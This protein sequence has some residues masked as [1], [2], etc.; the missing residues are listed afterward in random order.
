MGMS[1][2]DGEALANGFLYATNSLW[3]AERD[4]ASLT[5]VQALHFMHVRYS[6]LLVFASLCFFPTNTRYIATG[7]MDKIGWPFS[8]LN[9]LLQCQT[10]LVLTGASPQTG[11]QC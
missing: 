4:R 11:I 1:S 10:I 6:F 3:E 5:N 9:R 8:F 7:A 2:E